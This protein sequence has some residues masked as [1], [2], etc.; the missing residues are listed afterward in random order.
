MILVTKLS[1][2]PFLS[3]LVKNNEKPDKVPVTFSEDEDLDLCL[4][5]LRTLSN[6]LA[7]AGDISWAV[8]ASKH[9]S[10][11]GQQIQISSERP[12]CTFA[13]C[14]IDNGLSRGR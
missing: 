13:D 4:Y 5:Y 14:D 8:L 10:S 11:R 3:G 9:V 7:C 2:I 6:I 1:E 12:F